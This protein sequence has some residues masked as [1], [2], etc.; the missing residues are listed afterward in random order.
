MDLNGNGVTL[1]AQF[2][3]MILSYDIARDGE[4][5]VASVRN[6]QGGSDLW[7]VN[8][9]GTSKR[10]VVDC[11]QDHCESPTWSPDVQELIYNRIGNPSSISK[12]GVLSQIWQLNLE[13]MDNRPVFNGQFPQ[14]APDGQKLAY[15]DIEH[16]GVRVINLANSQNS[17]LKSN[18]S[19]IAWAPDSSGLI[20]FND[21]VELESHYINAFL[22]HFSSH[23][24][25]ILLDQYKDQFEFG[26]PVWSPD[27]DWI[28]MGV[29]LAQGGPSKQ[30]VMLHIDGSRVKTI[31]DTQVNTYSSY[32]WN[33][34]G[35]L[36]L[37][38]RLELGNS[39]AKPEIGLWDKT[40]ETIKILFGGGGTPNWLP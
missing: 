5:L 1:L 18:S 10:K 32:H 4:S 14:Y 30:L 34:D 6:Q 38:Q 25:E 19:V 2:D 13:T 36:L 31:T 16:S 23:Q 17:L 35:T 3:G 9:D 37:F 39:S 7:V 27:G 21:M 40:S 29:R 28:T 26:L 11:A 15:Y 20:Y 24:S 22:Y 33:P 8:R 12:P